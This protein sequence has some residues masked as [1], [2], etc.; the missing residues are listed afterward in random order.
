MRRIVLAIAPWILAACAAP[1]APGEGSIRLTADPGPPP[2]EA[3]PP[4]TLWRVGGE[5]WTPEDRVLAASADGRVRLGLDRRLRVDGRVVA[6]HGLPPLAVLPDGAVVV[7]RQ[8]APPERDLWRVEPDG[9]LRRLTEGGGSD[10]PIATP[11]G[12]LL[13]VSSVDGRAR[14][15]LDGAPLAGAEHAPPP[16]WADR[17]AWRD[18]RLEYDAGDARWWLDPD[19]A[20][21]RL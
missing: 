3:P 17:H 19:G 10:R 4:R 18:G 11:D 14:W 12:R 8:S 20:A 5:G 13:Y 6:E 1:D 15:M 16:A 9:R 7:T 21:G 2:L